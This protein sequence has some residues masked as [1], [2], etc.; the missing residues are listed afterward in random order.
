MLSVVSFIFENGPVLAGESLAIYFDN[1]CALSAL[2]KGAAKSEVLADLVHLF[3]FQA[4]QDD[5]KIWRE[6][7]PSARNIAD[8]PARNQRAPY[9][10]G[11][12][13]LFPHLLS[14]Y[15]IIKA[16]MSRA[17]QERDLFS[18]PKMS[19]HLA[20]QKYPKI[21]TRSHPYQPQTKW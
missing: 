11:E 13:G 1:H 7:S 5:I 14:L 10:A 3:W 19:S 18:G 9:Q 12:E 8:L 15:E 21:P 6:R 20:R 2:V 17:Q 4:H 16:K